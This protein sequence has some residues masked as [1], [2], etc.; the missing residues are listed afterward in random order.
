MRCDRDPSGTEEGG[1]GEIGKKKDR[2]MASQQEGVW[3][4]FLGVNNRGLAQKKGAAAP[5]RISGSKVTWMTGTTAVETGFGDER[6]GRS[7]GEKRER[8]KK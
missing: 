3:E 1:S 5:A 4:L 7:K 8:E 2:E 6:E